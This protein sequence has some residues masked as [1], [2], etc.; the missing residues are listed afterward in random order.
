[1]DRKDKIKDGVVFDN[2]T[3]K[4]EDSNSRSAK[5]YKALLKNT[6]IQ[7]I[8]YR[9]G[10]VF[11]SSV[12]FPYT[13][14]S[15]RENRKLYKK[16]LKEHKELLKE[17]ND[18]SQPII[19]KKEDKYYQKLSK[20]IESTNG[21]KAHNLFFTNEKGEKIP[22]PEE[23][24]KKINQSI[25][26]SILTQKQIA[27]RLLTLADTLNHSLHMYHDTTKDNS[28]FDNVED[29]ID[30]TSNLRQFIQRLKNNIGVLDDI[31]VILNK[32]YGGFVSYN[33]GNKIYE[34]NQEKHLLLKLN[35]Y[36][37]TIEKIT[38]ESSHISYQLGKINSF[39]SGID[40]H[41]TP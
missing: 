6:R 5:F 40:N 38:D 21:L 13:L 23:N 39:F 34:S 33:V 28:L 20:E 16:R 17:K 10:G 4:K 35:W 29:D 36:K 22:L 25:L 41:H 3:Q 30:F 12:M 2:Y 19:N 31:S 7:N 26:D 18:A 32:D 27:H 24:L 1:M 9:M 37:E 11:W 8:L 14:W 15:T